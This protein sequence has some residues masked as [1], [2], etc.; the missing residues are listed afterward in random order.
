M[1]KIDTVF[2]DWGGVVANDPGDDFLAQLLKKIGAT[3][4]QVASIFETYIKRFMRGQVTEQEYWQEIENNFGLHIPDTISDEFMR[5][6]GLTANQDILELVGELRQNGLRVAILSNV[7]E[8]TYNV[9][10]KAGYYDLFDEAIASCKVG[11]A[12]PEQEIYQISL[13]KLGATANT[14]LFIDDKQSNLDPAIQMGFSVIL[15]ENPEQ[16]IRD[17]RKQ[18]T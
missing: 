17:V 6:N 10:K 8:P 5:W 1:P 11:F 7:I 15:A 16:I 3:D 9:L 12:K 14:S 4:E 13:D 18:L 2:F